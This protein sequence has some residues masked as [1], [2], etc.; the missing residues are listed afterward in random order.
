MNERMNRVWAWFR[1]SGLISTALILAGVLTV[2]SAI[3]DWNDVPTGSMKPTIL[4]GDRIF[5][6][7]L[8]YDLKFPFTG[9]RLATWDNPARGDIVTCWS[10][11]NG[12]RLVKRVVGVPGDT[13][14]MQA[15]RLAINGQPL[16]YQPADQEFYSGLL[17]EDVQGKLFYTE[18]LVGVRHTVA[19]QPE[20]RAVRD[21][22]P[23]V[24]PSDQYFMM[25]DNRDNSADSRY[26]GFVDR[27]AIIGQATAVAL[28][29]D[30]DHWYQPRWSRFF[31]RLL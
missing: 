28:S 22:G 20:K 9:W 16:E 2:R 7:K 11:E 5:V 27:S 29:L 24:I 19:Y 13:I 30:Y 26:F 14:A 21:F 23:V 12:S 17:G 1:K 15:G 4:V 10:P 18:D 31:S 3:A 25:G 8:A 6:N